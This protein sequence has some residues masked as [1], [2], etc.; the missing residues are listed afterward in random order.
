MHS[1]LPVVCRHP[2][3]TDET[4]PTRLQNIPEREETSL[5]GE[6]LFRKAIAS[7]YIYI[8][9]S[10]R[11]SRY[12]SSSRLAKSWQISYRSSSS[13]RPRRASRKQIRECTKNGGCPHTG[14][15][16]PPNSRPGLDQQSRASFQFLVC[17]HRKAQ[18]E[19]GSKMEERDQRI[20]VSRLHSSSALAFQIFVSQTGI[21]SS[22]FQVSCHAFGTPRLFSTVQLPSPSPPISR[23]SQMQYSSR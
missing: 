19:R 11:S 12:V 15:G 20:K 22:R 17:S 16:A 2:R 21:L 14:V 23:L 13:L 4:R 5:W 3:S 18:Q 8:I 6:E 7:T 9:S 1:C 10:H